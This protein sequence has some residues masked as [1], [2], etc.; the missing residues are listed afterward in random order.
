MKQ[1][2]NKIALITG[3]NSGIGLATAKRFYEEGARVIITARSE[4]TYAT[5]LKTRGNKFEVI[6]ADVSR[7]QEIKGLMETIRKKHGHLDI[8]F[9][10]A[11]ISIVKPTLEFDE[12]SYDQSFD[13]NV[14][15]VFYTVKYALPLLKDGSSVVVNASQ[16]GHLGFSGTSVYGATKG[17]VLSLVR[18]WTAEF[19]ER[20]IRFNSVSPGLINT[21]II[22]KLGLPEEGV[23]FF[24]DFGKKNPIGRLGDPTEV[25]DAVLFLASNQSSYINGTDISIDGGGKAAPSMN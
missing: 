12:E 1:L 3:G 2:E 21:P 22:D 25:A 4:E 15:G 20:R 7:P 14:K 23:K 19:A 6:R 5:T 8:I 13:T 24:K 18:Q 16:A 10:N 11:G 9:A 17:A